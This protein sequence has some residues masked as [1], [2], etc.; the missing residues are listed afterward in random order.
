MVDYDLV[1]VGVY[2]V[3]VVYACSSIWGM[4][5]LGKINRIIALNKKDELRGRKE[6]VSKLEKN[7]SE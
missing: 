3:G 7:L 5:R 6:E 4:Y 2:A 1:K